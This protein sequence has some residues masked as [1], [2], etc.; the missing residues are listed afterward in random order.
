MVFVQQPPVQLQIAAVVSD[1]IDL[2]KI[3]LELQHALSSY[4]QAAITQYMQSY[5]QI[6]MGAIQAQ[7][8]GALQQS[9]ASM[10]A[11]I[12]NAMSFDQQTFMDAFQFNLS[13][14][15]LTRLMMSAMG[16]QDSNYDGN[17]RKLGYASF[18]E[19]SGI[20]IFPKDFESKGQILTILDSYN[21][22]MKSQGADDKVVT[23]TDLVGTLMSS[24]TTIVDMISTMLIAFV[25]ISLVVSS[26]MIGVITYISVLER[27]KEIGILRAMGASKGN[28]A[29]VFNAETLIVGFVAG[30]LG[31]G[32]TLLL[33]IPANFIVEVL[34]DIPNIAILPWQPSLI[35]VAVSMV[36]CLLAGLIPSSAASRKDPVEALRS[37]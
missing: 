8:A 18:D 5:M 35:L 6:V 2:D 22:E 16:S 19:P 28:I 34:M 27:K 23:Y 31:V 37:E 25:T 10:A 26:I 3:Q 14:D 1:A 29:N 13:Q 36:L 4:M 30:V 7:L 21:E 20:S 9:F 24:V 12:G 11:G 32:I 33:S 17:I 15:E